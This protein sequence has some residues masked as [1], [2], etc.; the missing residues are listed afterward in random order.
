MRSSNAAVEL[1]VN[2]WSDEH[3]QAM[4]VHASTRVLSAVDISQLC[5]TSLLVWFV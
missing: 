5:L 2:F 3:L 4:L 1:Y